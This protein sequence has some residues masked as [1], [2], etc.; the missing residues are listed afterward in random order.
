M[1]GSSGDI[2]ASGS[3]QFFNSQQK[4]LL[5]SQ[6]ALANFQAGQL[7]IQEDLQSTIRP[8]F[9]ESAEVSAED[10]DRALEGVFDEQGIQLNLVDLF[11]QDFDSQGTATPKQKWLGLGEAGGLAISNVLLAGLTGLFSPAAIP[12]AGFGATAGSAA[13][14]SAVGAGSA[15]FV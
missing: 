9:L 7:D 14:P 12:A 5:K 13:A 15:T 2:S 8:Q 11:N 6:L 10:A 4:K 1:S 3:N